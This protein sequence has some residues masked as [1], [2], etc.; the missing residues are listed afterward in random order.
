MELYINQNVKSKTQKEIIYLH[1]QLEVYNNPNY[2]NF[3]SYSY[4]E[5]KIDCNL[6]FLSYNYY[7]QAYFNPTII[8]NFHGYNYSF[9]TAFLNPLFNLG[10]LAILVNNNYI[11]PTSLA[12]LAL[13]FGAFYITNDVFSVI[14]NFESEES[15]Y[16]NSLS[17]H[18]MD[19]DYY[20]KQDESPKIFVDNI[21]QDS[22][23]RF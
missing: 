12:F 2:S 14:R 20:P 9:A 8:N 1:L 21:Y 22:K 13:S 6:S 4:K 19:L 18:E 7:S 5:D 11:L 10:F 23:D 17:V 16:F 15:D 3:I